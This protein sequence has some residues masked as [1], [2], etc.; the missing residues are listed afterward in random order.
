MSSN[1]SNFNESFFI[2][3]NRKKAT[4]NEYTKNVLEGRK[5]TAEKEQKKER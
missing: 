4:K 5:V 3:L 1:L 2:P